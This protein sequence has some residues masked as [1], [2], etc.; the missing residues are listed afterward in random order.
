MSVIVGVYVCERER[1]RERE[2][3]CVCVCVCACVCVHANMQRQL[4]H[5]SPALLL[6][7]LAH[8]PICCVC[9]WVRESVSKR[10]IV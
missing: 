8:T 6:R 7:G 2:R 3:V 4:T 1:Q 9:V 10:E 5:D